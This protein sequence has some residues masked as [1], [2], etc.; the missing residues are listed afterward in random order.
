MYI[1]TWNLTDHGT[2]LSLHFKT[3]IPSRCSTEARQVG[4][5]IFPA[6]KAT[7]TPHPQR[8]ASFTKCPQRHATKQDPELHPRRPGRPGLECRWN[9]EVKCAN[10]ANK[11]QDRGSQTQVSPCHCTTRSPLSLEAASPAQRQKKHTASPRW[12]GGGW[13]HTWVTPVHLGSHGPPQLTSQVMG[14]HPDLWW[15]VHPRH[16]PLSPQATL[17]ASFTGLAFTS[18]HCTLRTKSLFKWPLFLE[19]AA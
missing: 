15:P 12:T 11:G 17:S 7:S 19:E 18:Q 14:H 8:K 10:H 1:N 5:C 9:W 13:T 4:T 16:G 6:T 2:K 3:S